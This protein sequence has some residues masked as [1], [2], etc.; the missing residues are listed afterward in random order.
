MPNP[1]AHNLR[2]PCSSC[3]AQ[4]ASD[5]RYCI[6]CGQ[7]VGP[8]LA[9]PYGLP[10]PV[11]G[12]PTRASWTA[13]LP[14]P[15]QMV[16]AFAA[17]AL[18]FGAVVGTAISPNLADIV[19]AP[20]PSVVT[21]EPPAEPPT[22]A[23]GGG[24]FAGGG[25][26]AS[27]PTTAA[28]STPTSSI[29]GG[30]GG[31]GGGGAGG[32][33]TKK[34]KKKQPPAAQTFSGTVVRVNPVARSYT[35]STGGLVAIHA[36]S[37][38]DVGQK[39]ETPVRQ[40]RNGTYVENGQRNATG[41]ADSATFTGT[42]TYCADLQQP[43]VSCSEPIIAGDKYVYAVSSLGASVLV[44]APDA[45]APPPVGSRVEVTVRIG[46]KFEPIVPTSPTAPDPSCTPPPGG[47][48]SP[49]VTGPELAQT[50]ATVTGPS[51]SANLEAVVQITC[52]AESPSL[53]LSADDVRQAE[54]DLPI[55][56][57]PTGIDLA[58]LGIGQAVQAA[59]DIA[60][61]GT[62]LL[63]G[64]SSDQ[65]VAGAEDAAQRQGSLAGS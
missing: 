65:G 40:L 63:K 31:G 35:I 44:S 60:A 28:S 13:S 64:I 53:I 29:G 57:V 2:G 55:F 39:V 8:P 43:A 34:K 4:L 42:V 51:T 23:G 18:G 19:A 59:V 21:D 24:G 56:A 3:G 41:P 27:A 61:D 14:M 10:A 45:V 50:A 38:P 33:G 5:Q 22:G 12:S 15:L 62:L 20:G 48:P 11:S 49:P 7:R 25:G 17:L 9:L 30:G 46:S 1:E 32:G 54:R 36:E 47:L 52:P 37:L 58:K 16:S 26:V 6:E